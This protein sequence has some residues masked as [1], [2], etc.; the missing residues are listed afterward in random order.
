M[1]NIA[2]ILFTL[3][4]FTVSATEQ[5]LDKLIYKTDTI[6]ISTFPLNTLIETYPLIKKKLFH[7][8]DTICE[9]T[10][11][12]RGYIGTWKIENDS[13]F[14]IKLTNGC[15]NHIFNLN[16]VFSK[17]KTQNKRIFANWYTGEIKTMFNYKKVSDGKTE[18][19]IPTNSFSTKIINGKIISISIE[20]IN[21][22]Q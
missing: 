8:S 2:I 12:W 18:E 13:L 20:T 6:G 22:R 4:S 5:T 21:D 7:Y 9:S 16:K 15:E 11:C 17:R 3:I 19:Y 10:D 14:L 1:K